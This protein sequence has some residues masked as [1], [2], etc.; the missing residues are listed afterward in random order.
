MSVSTA[1]LAKQKILDLLNARTALAAMVTADQLK[2]RWAAPTE[3]AD[4]RRDIIWL[5]DVE[6]TEEH[7]ALGGNGIRKDEDYTIQLWCQSYRVGDDPKATEE[8]CWALREEAAAA[9]R[10]DPNLS[11]VLNQWVEIEST[12]V[13]T[14]PAEKGWL[15]KCEA[16][17]LCH[18][19]I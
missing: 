15:V 19:R 17:L 3:E 16:S 18:A 8:A 1:P 7:I 14:R 13:I 12:N 6:Q 11:G 10:L 4:Y 5:G 9:I 2:I